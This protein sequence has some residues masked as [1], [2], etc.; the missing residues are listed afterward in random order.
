[1]RGGDRESGDRLGPD[2]LLD[3]L[4]AQLE[5]FRLLPG[6]S[7]AD[8]ERVLAGLTPASKRELEATAELSDRRVLAHP[9]RFEDAHRLTV[10]ALEVFDR[11]GWRAPGL[12]GWLG[13][14]RAVAR[15]PIE[16]VTRY[17]VKGYAEDVVRQLERLYARREA[18][19][20][21]DAPE[22]RLLTRARIAM[23]RLSPDFRGGQTGLPRFL[24]GGAALS[25]LASLVRQ[26][27][28][29]GDHR[30]Q[31]VLLAIATFAIFGA[32]S[33]ILVQG[34]AVAHRRSKLIMSAPL[35]ALWETI[36]NC[37]RPP[38]DDSVTIAA[39]GIAITATAWFVVP[40]IVA[41]AF[42]LVD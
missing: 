33:W 4:T 3:D 13:P 40:V 19:C 38:Q 28:G 2:L 9:E 41:V 42:Y 12:P 22:R 5:R 35:A 16:L 10:K 6:G 11:H 29:S 21:P 14:L 27:A 30:A 18:Q 7:D 23:G 32:V 34:A 15:Y 39:V 25:G 31:I 24:V 20:A 1:M 17:I 37:G 36:G 26:F 8:A